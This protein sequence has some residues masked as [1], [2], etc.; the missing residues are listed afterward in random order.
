MLLSARIAVEELQRK[1]YQRQAGEAAACWDRGRRWAYPA[2]IDRFTAALVTAAN[3]DLSH[4][5][6]PRTL[7]AP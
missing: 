6:P 2:G 5:R 7:F 4:A 1:G 3:W